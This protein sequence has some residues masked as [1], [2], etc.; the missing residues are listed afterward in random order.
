MIFFRADSN[1]QIASGHIMR[2]LS[3][4]QA[5]SE[6]GEEVEFL[7]ADENPIS[8]LERA[9]VKYTVLHSVWNNLMDEVERMKVKL[10]E[11][12]NPLLLI[13]TYYVSRQYVEALLPYARI[14][15][16]GSK[17]E[18]LGPLQALINYSTDIDYDFY[19]SNYSTNSKLLL[20][21]AYGPLR[22]EFLEVRHSDDKNGRCRILLTTGNTDARNSVGKILA[23]LLRVKVSHQIEV[24]VVVGGMFETKE[25]L[26][27]LYDGSD[28]VVLHENV[29][30]MSSLMA[31]CDL[32]V[33]A[34]GTTVYELSAAKVPTISFAMVEE[35]VKSARKLS[36]LG[37][38]DYCG[39]FYNE[40]EAVV[41]S[42]VESVQKYVLNP[43][44]RVQL[45]EKANSVVDGKGCE[46]IV[47]TLLKL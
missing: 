38:V 40:E 34:N 9:G 24:H 30:S 22:K 12:N 43:Q 6:A 39:E 5:F 33:S 3:I 41:N 45:A 29:K 25:S 47:E 15:Y 19:Q 35:Q 23:Q 13:D 46:R 42:I 17:P 21:A 27:Q 2:C 31:N 18:Y 36:E 28:K 20:G 16:L 26:H 32:A 44:A 8:M 4:A 7:I 14:C 10:Q 37:V 1:K 11:F